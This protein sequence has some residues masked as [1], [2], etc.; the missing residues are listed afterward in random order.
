MVH[1]QLLLAIYCCLC[2]KSFGVAA[3]RLPLTKEKSVLLFTKSLYSCSSWRRCFH[4]ASALATMNG[5][6]YA[7]LNSP[8]GPKRQLLGNHAGHAAPAWK[9]PQ[10]QVPV[11]K[12]KRIMDQ[13]SK[14]LL[15]RLPSDV[16]E[17]D[18]VVSISALG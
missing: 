7:R 4:L 10:F 9:N 17:S 2:T 8:H 12:G 16:P 1:I 6:P 14:I 18:V 11:G 15:T 13:G 3:T 5:Q